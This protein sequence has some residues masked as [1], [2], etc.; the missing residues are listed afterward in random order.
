MTDKSKQELIIKILEET[1]CFTENLLKENDRLR[2]IVAGL[3][4][5]KDTPL[6]VRKKPEELLGSLEEKVDFLIQENSLLQQEL[7][8]I[9]TEIAKAE[10]ESRDYYSRYTEVEQQNETLANLYVT[11]H[12]LHSTFQFVEVLESIKE[13]IINLVGS[14]SFA[15]FWVDEQARQLRVI[16]SEGEAAASQATILFGP[17][18][19]SKA[20][21]T[22]EI[23][24]S[25]TNDNS[26][27]PMACIPLKAF[28]RVIGVVVI[29]HLLAHKSSFS[30]TDFE[31]FEL[32]AD[33]AAAA[34]VSSLLIAQVGDN[35][36]DYISTTKLLQVM[37]SSTI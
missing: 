7:D 28:G 11:I 35:L 2:L 9:K 17:N 37:P 8:V 30:Q 19:I 6:E 24:I 3:K 15:I 23:F 13:I 33:H 34:I 4:A 21:Q 14:E 18:L 20:A 32:M 29:Y 36:N 27:E 25:M 31:L 1:K 16:T 26:Q 10:A 22:G 12:R 5:G